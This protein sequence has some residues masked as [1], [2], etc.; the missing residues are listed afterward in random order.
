MISGTL[1]TGFSVVS[2]VGC[3]NP[4][5]DAQA[6]MIEAQPSEFVDLF[7]GGVV[8][9]ARDIQRPIEHIGIERKR[10]VM[11][12]RTIRIRELSQGVAQAP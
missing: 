11:G 5:P 9:T 3:G 6:P 2:S 1:L 8:I 7:N 10:S 12:F 4:A